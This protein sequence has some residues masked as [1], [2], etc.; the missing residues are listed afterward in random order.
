MLQVL[1]DGELQLR[2]EVMHATVRKDGRIHHRSASATDRPTT[3]AQHL[4]SALTGPKKELASACCKGRRLPAEGCF[5]PRAKRPYSAHEVVNEAS[6][7]HL[8]S[9]LPCSAIASDREKSLRKWATL[10]T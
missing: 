4:L 5:A 3:V 1:N 2:P 9:G 8:Y 10:P 6:F 7:T